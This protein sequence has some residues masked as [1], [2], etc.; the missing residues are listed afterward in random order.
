MFIKL[1][2]LNLTIKLH[3]NVTK[4]FYNQIRHTNI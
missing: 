3:F 1:L 2:V 4:Y